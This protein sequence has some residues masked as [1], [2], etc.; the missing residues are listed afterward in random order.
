[1]K[2]L[3]SRSG[4]GFRTRLM[5]RP[6]AMS[7]AAAIGA[8][9]RFLLVGVFESNRTPDEER[10]WYVQFRPARADRM[11]R[12]LEEHRSV[13]EQRARDQADHYAVVRD[14]AG[15]HFWVYN[16]RSGECY[17]TTVQGDCDC[18]HATYRTNGVP[19]VIC[20]HSALLS[21]KLRGGEV[22][23]F[24]APVP[25]CDQEGRVRVD[26][27]TGEALAPESAGDA[28]VYA[29]RREPVP[30]LTDRS[31]DHSSMWPEEWAP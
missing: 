21:L 27:L 23:E 26:V 1:M 25:P 18:P 14:P 7:F 9:Q 6:R 30:I 11:L 16:L 12:I 17:C 24:D 10:R 5:T 22:Q 31:R 13:A 19:G 15:T 8:N 28:A 29:P 4:A 3:S 2:T 20:K